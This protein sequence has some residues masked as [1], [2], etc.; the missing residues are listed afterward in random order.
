M[1]AL[2]ELLSSELFQRIGWTL[3]HSIWQMVVVA[4]LLWIVLQCT[5]RNRHKIRWLCACGALGLMAIAPVAT[6]LMTPERVIEPP[7]ELVVE[8][9][10]PLISS[11]PKPK[12]G[13]PKG[14]APRRRSFVE[15]APPARGELIAV[16]RDIS[17]I[18]LAAIKIAP[19][20]PYMVGLWLA[21]VVGMSLWHTG[22]LLL[23]ADIKR[24]GTLPADDS[25]EEIFR[26]LV[27]RL[28]V[29]IPVRLA[30]SAK[31]M[32]PCVLG[33]FRPVVLLPMAILSGLSNEQLEAVLAHELAH[34]RRYDCLVRLMQAMVETVLFYHPAVWWVSSRIRQ[35]SEH[36]CDE[37]AITAC[38][39]RSNYA[40]ALIRVAELGR[41]EHHLV[42]AA[43]DG[44]LTTRI[45]RILRMKVD[46][47]AGVR[48]LTFVLSMT[49]T[50][51]IAA[52]LTVAMVYEDVD[53]ID[54][55]DRLPVAQLVF[56]PST[57]PY[58]ELGYVQSLQNWW[59]RT[60][61]PEGLKLP[62]FR[63]AQPRFMLYHSSLLDPNST[64]QVVGDPRSDPGIW[65]AV[66]DPTDD[67][68]DARLYIDTNGNK[69][70][71]D[72]EPILPVAIGVHDGPQGYHDVRFG[73][74][75]IDHPGRANMPSVPLI[76]SYWQ[77]HK[78]YFLCFTTAGWYQGRV[79]IGE[80][81]YDCLLV[82]NDADGKFNNSSVSFG[83]ADRFF[84]GE[85]RIEYMP[86]KYAQVD[87]K[88][89]HP[90]IAM[91]GSSIEFVPAEYEAVGTVSV[92]SD[93]DLLIAA[94]E[95]GMLDAEV[96]DGV[97]ELPIGRYR[98]HSTRV[99]RVD[100]DG[101]TWSI[102]GSK[103]RDGGVFQVVEDTETPLSLGAPIDVRLN[104]RVNADGVY[105]MNYAL[106]NPLDGTMLMTLDGENAPLA[107]LH[108]SNTDGTYSESLLFAPF[109][110]KY[111]EELKFDNRRTLGM[112]D[113]QV[114]EGVTGP[115]NFELQMPGPFEFK[116]KL[117]LSLP[118]MQQLVW[119]FKVTSGG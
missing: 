55:L 98:L 70:L 112:L 94:G 69:S 26:K 100:A 34:I 88:V 64:Y 6:F 38:P 63:S 80:E 74:V 18:E 23:L 54:D 36:C 116:E 52:S 78:N 41:S 43:S 40:S 33:W 7:Q 105:Q 49:I 65:C 30:H 87:G 53:D 115:F 102:D 57:D 101:R 42:A 1:S 83:F 37:L 22:G 21:G 48:G 12:L 28:K 95:N 97:G 117:M 27:K 59:M 73:V 47:H 13:D 77:Y 14:D 2:I 31:V 82:D 9:A 89:Y 113:W 15:D 109:V 66:D 81:V 67:P 19:A 10:A 39:D 84:L 61:V 29:K 114:P 4:A 35:E 118:M 91:D 79:D 11:A 111:G 51:A 71:A 46:S 107:T 60:D 76:V 8:T 68:A 119:K 85:Q 58:H 24:R 106:H 62:V 20:L 99:S 3:I 56:R 5:P 96:V 108:V 110:P 32:V 75:N 44:Q 17:M 16:E 50:L 86:G 25:T 45:R 104:F 93:V 103:F 72:E 90:V 92:G